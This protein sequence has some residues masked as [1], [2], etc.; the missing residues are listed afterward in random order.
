M[1][2]KAALKRPH[3]TLREKVCCWRG[4]ASVWSAEFIPLLGASAC[5]W[6][7]ESQSGGAAAGY[8]RA[9]RDFYLE[10]GELKYLYLRELCLSSGIKSL[11]SPPMKYP[12]KQTNCWHFLIVKILVS[13]YT[14]ENGCIINTLRRVFMHQ[15]PRSRCVFSKFPDLKPQTQWQSNSMTKKQDKKS[16]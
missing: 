9:S 15:S 3:Q 14:R 8:G 13:I 12:W 2:R 1:R 11:R 6:E 4:R 5:S 7:S 16:I 10:H